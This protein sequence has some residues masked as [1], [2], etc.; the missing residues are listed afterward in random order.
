MKKIQ[1]MR[2][3]KKRKSLKRNRRKNQLQA[4]QCSLNSRA[5]SGVS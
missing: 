1:K 4:V 3:R 5:Q 2:G